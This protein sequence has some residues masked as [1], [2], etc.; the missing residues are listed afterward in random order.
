M[1]RTEVGRVKEGGRTDEARPPPAS[2]TAAAVFTSPVLCDVAN[3]LKTNFNVVDS[4]EPQL[5]IKM[6]QVVATVKRNI[7]NLGSSS[8]YEDLDG[9]VSGSVRGAPAMLSGSG[10]AGDFNENLPTLGQDIEMTS[11]SVVPDGE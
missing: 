6:S 3:V 8:K 11:V 7:K 1:R 9:S 2:A 4:F 5:F 10:G